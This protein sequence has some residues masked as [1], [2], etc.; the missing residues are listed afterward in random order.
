MS[1]SFICYHLNLSVTDW[2]NIKLFKHVKKTKLVSKL[3][4][5]KGGSDNGS[6]TWEQAWELLLPEQKCIL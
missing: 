6:L 3:Y 4:A 5:D 2:V 1:V